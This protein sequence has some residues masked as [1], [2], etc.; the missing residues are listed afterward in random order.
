METTERK[1]TNEFF[2]NL[3]RNETVKTELSTESTLKTIANIVLAFGVI[4]TI[5]LLTT[6]VWVDVGVYITDIV[7]NPSALVVSIGVLLGTL[8]SWA[9]L[10]VLADIS[11][12][13]KEI[14]SKM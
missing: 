3:E 5:I 4:A 2:E 12:N 14:N 8:I 9:L 6:T 11:I 1:V 13:L 10:R 7:F